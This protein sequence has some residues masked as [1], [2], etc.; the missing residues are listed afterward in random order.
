VARTKKVHRVYRFRQQPLHDAPALPLTVQLVSSAV[1][2][3][4]ISKDNIGKNRSADK[5]KCFCPRG[6]IFFD[7]FRSGDVARHE[8]RRELNTA[9]F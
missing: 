7:N 2:G 5:L 9:E 6:D 4:F 1:Y 8:I 3:L